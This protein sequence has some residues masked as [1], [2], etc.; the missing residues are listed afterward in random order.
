MYKKIESVE[1]FEQFLSL[2]TRKKLALLN[3]LKNWIS[4]KDLVERASM[5]P[6]DLNDEIKLM[7]ELGIA[8]VR[9]TQYGNT[10]VK[11]YK[12]DA[13]MIVNMCPMML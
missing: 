11:E 7:A 4:I 2:F 10:T 6:E 13:V 1:E 5:S 9:L 8:K 3:H 12:M